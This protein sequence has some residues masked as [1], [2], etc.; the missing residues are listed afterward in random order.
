ATS[1]RGVGRQRGGSLI[2]AVGE[3][4]CSARARSSSA[5]WRALK[6]LLMTSL[7]QHRLRPNQ[8][9]E[10]VPREQHETLQ[11]PCDSV[12]ERKRDTRRERKHDSATR[13]RRHPCRDHP[14]VGG[15][16]R[17]G[18]SLHLLGR[19]GLDEAIALRFID[20]W[21]GRLVHHTKRLRGSYLR[22][23]RYRNRR[24]DCSLTRF[25]AWIA[26]WFGTTSRSP[27]LRGWALS[28]F[29]VVDGFFHR[30]HVDGAILVGVAGD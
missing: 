25:G 1:A 7:G 30:T 9:A 17:G 10:P 18:K 26:R 4:P 2:K 19:E 20:L 24:R 12:D 15:D 21:R 13:R 29:E 5:C 11:R 22:L 14:A 3:E 23:W 28:L 27:R 8:G 16:F 6:N